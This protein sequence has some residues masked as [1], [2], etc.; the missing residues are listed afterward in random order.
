MSGA[1][2]VTSVYEITGD[3]D[4][5]PRFDR[6]GH[7]WLLPLAGWRG[8]EVELLEAEG[9]RATA[10]SCD[11][12]PARRRGRF[13][14]RS[15]RPGGLAMQARGRQL[16]MRIRTT[17]LTCRSQESGLDSRAWQVSNRHGSNSRECGQE[18]RR[19]DRTRVQ[20]QQPPSGR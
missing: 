4:T 3:A 20:P 18:P 5:N 9:C 16:Q 1:Q 13:Q 19:M 10:F 7:W 2:S 15:P 6:W 12:A 17:M 8:S 14:P 11:R